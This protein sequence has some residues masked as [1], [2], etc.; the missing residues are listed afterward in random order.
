MSHR[1]DANQRH[2]L[3]AGHVDPESDRERLSDL[4]DADN[5]SLKD[6]AHR[7]WQDLPARN[8]LFYPIADLDL[9]PLRRVGDLAD[10]FVLCDWRWPCCPEV[11][12]AA[13]LPKTPACATSG[14]G[15]PSRATT[16]MAA[17]RDCRRELRFG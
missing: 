5:K 17:Q 9:E 12:P 13:K 3:N 11:P 4:I 15:E 2:K 7:L 6:E 8:V 10:V 1:S 14:R 16:I